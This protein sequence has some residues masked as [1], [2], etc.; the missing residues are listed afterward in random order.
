VS[1]VATP[2]WRI[3]ALAGSEQIVYM[4]PEDRLM[5]SNKAFEITELKAGRHVETRHPARRASM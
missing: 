2:L 4:L 3:L 1:Y 5:C